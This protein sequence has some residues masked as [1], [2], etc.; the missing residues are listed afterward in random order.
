M[1]TTSNDLK[2]QFV[3]VTPERFAAYRESVRHIEGFEEGQDVGRTH[4]M[5]VIYVH[6]A[7]T[8][9]WSWTIEEGPLGRVDRV[10]SHE[11]RADLAPEQPVY[12][13]NRYFVIDLTKL[14]ADQKKALDGALGLLAIESKAG[15]FFG[16]KNP[17]YPT[18]HQLLVDKIKEAQ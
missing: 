2:P 6:G 4:G 16:L 15:L 1:T 11:L 7:Q 18:V 5:G 17:L 9:S 10:W 8:G 14:T 12:V 3:Q 13:E